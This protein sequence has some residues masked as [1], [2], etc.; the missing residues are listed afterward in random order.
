MRPMSAVSWPEMPEDNSSLGLV[1]DNSSLGLVMDNSSLGLFMDNTGP[2]LVMNNSSF[3]LFL[4]Q[5]TAINEPVDHVYGWLS[6]VIGVLTIAV[7]SWAIW[8]LRTKVNELTSNLLICDCVSNILISF[9]VI[10]LNSYFWFPIKNPIICAVQSSIIVTLG[11]FTRLVPVSIVLLRYIMVC[12][13]AFHMNNGK[14]G[15]WKWIIG[16][17]TILCLLFW[18]YM[19]ILS[20]DRYRFLQ[21]MGR[22]EAFW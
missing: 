4:D 8:V 9:N 18:V 16:G 14:D 6:C 17:L 22:E 21:C 10:F 2:D 3:G 7:N 15:I 1:M 19:M 20:P 5:T 11:T 12:Q 13:P